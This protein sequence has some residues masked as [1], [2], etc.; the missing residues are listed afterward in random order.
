LW[1]RDGGSGAAGKGEAEMDGGCGYVN[2]LLAFIFLVFFFRSSLS[3]VFCYLNW[4]RDE[5]R[6]IPCFRARMVVIRRE[7]EEN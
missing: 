2:V 1:R 4:R 5:C 6:S 7:K 3:L